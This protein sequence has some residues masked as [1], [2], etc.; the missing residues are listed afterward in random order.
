MNSISSYTFAS[1]FRNNSI[2]KLK[3]LIQLNIGKGLRSNILIKGSR[4][5]RMERVVDEITRSF[6]RTC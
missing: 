6:P 4:S 1:E 5:S 3:E 2:S